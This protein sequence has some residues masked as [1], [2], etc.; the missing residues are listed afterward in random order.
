[1]AG[2]ACSLGHNDCKPVRLA[3]LGIPEKGFSKSQPSER[4]GQAQG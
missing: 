2:Q 3:M 4:E 1:M